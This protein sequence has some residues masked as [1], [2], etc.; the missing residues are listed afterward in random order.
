M[1]ISLVAALG[2]P[3]RDYEN[4]RHNLGWIVADALVRRE[5]LS[6]QRMSRFDA[7]IA[8]WDLAP[9]H[10]VWFCKPLLFMN[11]SGIPVQ[12]FARFHQIQPASI[13]AV[14]D[15]VAIPLGRVKVSET[16]SAG[17]HNGV[18]SLLEHLGDGFVRFRLGI[19]P[20]E[21][22]EMDL[23]DFVLG[24]LSPSQLQIIDQNLKTFLQ[25]LDLLLTGGVARAMNLLN[26]RDQNETEQT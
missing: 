14:Y 10:T 25:G 1:S 7:E 16:G 19:G 24:Q 8:R 13:A 9:G 11:E 23:K 2:N 26:R 17:G 3:G 15:D 21:P 6:W 4:S 5:K 20:K 18:A 12:A 22:A